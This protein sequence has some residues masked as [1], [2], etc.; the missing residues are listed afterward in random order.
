MESYHS[1]ATV[2]GTTCSV[3]A[4]PSAVIECK[5]SWMD[6]NHNIIDYYIPRKLATIGLPTQFTRIVELLNADNYL[7]LWCPGICLWVKSGL[8][9]FLA[10]LLFISILHA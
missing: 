4:C 1:C 2:Y 7:A 10:I 6:S 5:V 8:I 3:L 9:F